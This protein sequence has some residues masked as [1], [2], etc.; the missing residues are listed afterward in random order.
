MKKMMLL[1]MILMMAIPNVFA[2]EV[3]GDVSIINGVEVV[4]LWGTHY[5]RGYAQGYLMPEKAE[6]TFT[7]FA[8]DNFFAYY[9]IDYPTAR[10]FFLDN[11]VV[12][13]KYIDEA[14]GTIDGMVAADYSLYNESLGRDLDHLDWL[15]MTGLTEYAFMPTLSGVPS[16]ENIHCS[17][18]SSWGSATQDDP[19]LRGAMVVTRNFD[20]ITENYPN[21]QYNLTIH[22]PSEADELNWIQPSFF[23]GAINVNGAINELGF[24]VFN[25]DGNF[26]SNSNVTNLYPS[27]LTW[28][29]CI[30]MEDGNGDGTHNLDDYVWQRDQHTYLYPSI[31][32][33]VSPDSAIILETNNSGA[34]QRSVVDNVV[35]NGNN[36]AATNHFRELYAPTACS[37]FSNIKDSLNANSN[38]TIERSWDM[39]GA[40]AGVSFNQQK[41]EYIPAHNILKYAYVGADGTPAYQMEPAIFNTD[42]LFSQT[43]LVTDVTIQVANENV[44]GCAQVSNPLDNQIEVWGLLNS[45]EHGVVDSTQMFDDGMHGD[46]EAGDGVFGGS[47]SL[48]VEEGFYTL[49]SK[50]VNLDFGFTHQAQSEVFATNGPLQVHSYIQLH[51]SGGVIEGGANVY[52]DL[53]IQNAGLTDTL[54]DIVV[55]MYPVDT[56]STSLGMS[57]IAYPDLAPGEFSDDENPG[58]YFSV[59]INEN[60]TV[61]TQILLGVELSSGDMVG[62]QDTLVLG[63]VDIEEQSLRPLQFALQQNF[64]NP[65]NPSTT[66]S[67]ELPTQS[68]VR[69]VVYDILGQEVATLV[70][71]NQS[72]GY[73]SIQWDGLN[74]QGQQLSTG[75][76]LYVIHAGEFTQTRKMLLLN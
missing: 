13:Q 57:S 31:V 23:P 6:E 27:Q 43:P 8:L 66:I 9:D 61:G 15:V 29:N 52:L 55:N 35:I 70:S 64:P 40:A 48:Q 38:L 36:L 75:M 34:T 58:S 2:Q 50:V 32:T 65:F 24:A 68:D 42:F 63:W 1:T 5:E 76:Y 53:L 56:M 39:M 30:E 37:R 51:P 60:A 62:W 18:L 14:V 71:E 67:Y 20:W 69:I 59:N 4:R 46:G 41:I 45:Y 3:N 44:A 33:C 26:Y 25:N 47:M 12:E 11:Y 72:V 7:G 19:E 16:Y 28:R 22:Y 17:T 74:T 73:K 21:D 49:D 10:Q 54:R